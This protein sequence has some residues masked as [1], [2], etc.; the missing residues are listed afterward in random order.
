[1]AKGQNPR[2]AGGKGSSCKSRRGPRKLTMP[3][4]VDISGPIAAERP[5]FAE[6][7][8]TPTPKRFSVQHGSDKQ[9]YPI[10]DS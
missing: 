4:L 1:M 9:G 5:Q 8:P 7:T 3:A 10:L 6:A 2:Q